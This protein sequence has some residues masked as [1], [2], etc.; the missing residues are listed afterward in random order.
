M[1]AIASVADKGEKMSLI[2]EMIE[3][4]P[5]YVTAKVETECPMCGEWIYQIGVF[6]KRDQY[7]V[8]TLMKNIAEVCKSCGWNQYS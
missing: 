2:V 5:S 4:G 7:E 1:I 6:E 8:G 3:E